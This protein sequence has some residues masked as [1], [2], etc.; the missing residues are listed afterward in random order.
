MPLTTDEKLLGLSRSVIEAL[1]K[2]DGGVHPGFRPAHAKGILLTGVFTSPPE[3]D[4]STL[5]LQRVYKA[6]WLLHCRAS[7]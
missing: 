4:L 1:D 5:S 2:A 3:A 7:G 6:H